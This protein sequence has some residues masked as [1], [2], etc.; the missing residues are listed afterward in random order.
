MQQVKQLE[1]GSPLSRSD[2]LMTNT[3]GS[4]INGRGSGGP[5][6]SGLLKHKPAPLNQALQAQSPSHA[7]R[8]E[9][10]NSDIMVLMSKPKNGKLDPLK[11]T[12][13]IHTSSYSQGTSDSYEGS[14]R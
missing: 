5:N 10:L 7:K 13:S 9:E 14:G 6:I 12:K 2:I 8:G 1:V 4:P 3:K 11:L